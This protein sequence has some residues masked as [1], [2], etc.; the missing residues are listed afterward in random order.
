MYS[1]MP[2]KPKIRIFFRF[3]LPTIIDIGKS[4]SN[5][6]FFHITYVSFNAKISESTVSFGLC[7]CM[8]NSLRDSSSV[9]SSFVFACLFAQ[10]QVILDCI[11]PSIPFKHKRLSIIL[12]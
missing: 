11:I 10:N 5:R 3:G 8:G 2:T 7:I 1:K 9:S 12:I 6:D 4:C